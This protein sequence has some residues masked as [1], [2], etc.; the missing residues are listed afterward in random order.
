M[1]LIQLDFHARTLAMDQSVYIILPEEKRDTE[2]PYFHAG[3]APL[4]ERHPVLYLLHGTS[5]DYSE[6]LRYTA[7]ERYAN[8]RGIAVVMPSAQLSA[9]ADM[10][11]GEDFFTYITQELPTVVEHAFPLSNCREERFVCGLSMGGYG[12]AKIGLTLPHRYGAVGILSSCNLAYKRVLDKNPTRPDAM[13]GRLV[14]DR[15]LLC[16]GAGEGE[17]P[18]GTSH[19][20]YALA[21]GALQAGG[22]LPALFHMVGTADRNL[23]SARHMRDFFRSLPGDPFHYAYFEAVLEDHTWACWDKWIQIF[24]DWLPVWL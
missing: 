3:R 11:H 1:S 22:D 4:R 21:Q 15:H 8:E 12:A 7:V 24:L 18:V 5:Q 23:R 19:D 20:L 2:V 13:P 6:W 17:A 16:W 14:D 10:A 9:Y